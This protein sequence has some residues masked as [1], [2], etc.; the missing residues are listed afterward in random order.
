MEVAH[1]ESMGSIDT[2]QEDI[3]RMQSD[4]SAHAAECARLRETANIE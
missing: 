3:L 1:K 2:M 4:L